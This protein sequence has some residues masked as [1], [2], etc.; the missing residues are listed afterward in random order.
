MTDAEIKALLDTIPRE[1]RNSLDGILSTAKTIAA[2]RMRVPGNEID[3]AVVRNG[4]F[5]GHSA[6][7]KLLRISQN[8]VINDPQYASKLPASWAKLYVLS[9]VPDNDLLE[10]LR[11]GTIH[12]GVDKQAVLDL[13]RRKS[14]GELEVERLSYG[15]AAA[16]STRL[17]LPSVPRGELILRATRG[18]ALE[19]SG[20]LSKDIPKQIG[21][22]AFIYVMARD[23]ILLSERADLNAYDTSVAREAFAAIRA[24]DP[25]LKTAHASVRELI[26]RVLGRSGNSRISRA[27]VKSTKQSEAYRRGIMLF[28]DSIETLLDGGDPPYLGGLE[29]HVAI[30]K[31]LKESQSNTRKLVKYICGQIKLFATKGKS[32]G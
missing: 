21:L 13:R 7:N 14:S 29:E 9:C 25:D 23:I 22:N 32:H 26:G 1:W 28:C 4:M 31:R 6:I 2:I 16:S 8:K 30:L 24:D 17:H 18:T 5:L 20:V 19:R 11:D 27:R 12:P 3:E 10:K 15:P